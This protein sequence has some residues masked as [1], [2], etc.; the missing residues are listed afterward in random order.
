MT[1]RISS[2]QIYQEQGALEIIRWQE[3]IVKAEATE[4]K[5]TWHHQ[6]Q[7]SRHSKSWIHHNIR[8]ARYGSKVTSHDEDDGRL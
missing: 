7:L 6:T 1:G 3:E 2:N 4:T 8:K 5:V